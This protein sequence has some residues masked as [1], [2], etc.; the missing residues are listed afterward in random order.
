MAVIRSE[1]LPLNIPTFIFCPQVNL[2]NGSVNL[3][4]AEGVMHD[5]FVSSIVG[6]GELTSVQSLPASRVAAVS[7][8]QTTI[9]ST[10][11]NQLAPAS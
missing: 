11:K 10:I 9:F 2:N 7:L 4:L 5:V 1:H 6:G 3:A 8:L